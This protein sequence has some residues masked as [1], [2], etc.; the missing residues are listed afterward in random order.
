MEPTFSSLGIGAGLCDAL[1]RGG[2]SAP[3]PVQQKTIPFALSG[4]DVIVQAQTGTGKTLAFLLPLLE[5]SAPRNEFVRVLILTPTRELAIQ[6]ASEAR[7]LADAV[8]S[9]VMSVYG[10]QDVIAQAHK[11]G[12]SPDIVI[13]TPGR[14]LDHIRRGTID[15]SRLSALVLDEADQML[16]MGFLPEVEEVIRQTPDDRQTMLFSATFPESVRVLSER[17]MKRPQDIR[18]QGKRIT[19]DEIR[20]YVVETTDRQKKDT[21]VKLLM[22]NPPFLAVIFCRTKI[23]AKKLAES[24]ASDGLSVDELHGDLTQAKREAV[25]RRFRNAQ[26][27]LLVATDVAARGLDVDGVTHVY[28]YDIPQDPESYIHRIGRTGRAGQQGTAVT[29]VAPKDIGELKEIE[30]AI[31]SVLERKAVQGAQTNEDGR[32]PAAAKPSSGAGHERE[33]KRWQGRS[34]SA[35]ANVGGL[36]GKSG[37]TRRSTAGVP[38]RTEDQPA[39]TRRSG[40]EPATNPREQKGGSRKGR[41]EFAANPGNRRDGNK[42]GGRRDAAADQAGS[43]REAVNPGSRPEAVKTGERRNSAKPGKRSAASDSGQWFNAKPGRS[44]DSAAYPAKRPD[45]AKPGRRGESASFGSSRKD[46][47]LSAS[48]PGSRSGRTGRRK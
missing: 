17:Y 32:R 2:L 39:R 12:G 11:L 30:R 36:A 45:N 40:S 16:H 21:L 33:G 15:L 44:A 35:R 18:V 27:Q 41:T 3:T 23:R 22:Q 8:G 1:R 28:N 6:I 37:G 43:R 42:P 10:G 25:M 47:R 38:A 5:K 26:L 13:A 9:T 46:T 34:P 29:L 24:L 19:L 48:R 20:Q 31:G 14:L 7:K 4:K